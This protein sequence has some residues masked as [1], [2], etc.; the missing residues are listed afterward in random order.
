M[1]SNEKHPDLDQ[2]RARQTELVLGLARESSSARLAA[3]S[4]E[5]EELLNLIQAREAEAR[6]QAPAREEQRSEVPQ[7]ED[8]VVIEPDADLDRDL[9]RNLGDG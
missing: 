3:M 4:D 1:A 2:L 9:R 8:G 6:Q 7:R 5:L